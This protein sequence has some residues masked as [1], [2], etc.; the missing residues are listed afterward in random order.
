MRVADQ[1]VWGTNHTSLS[2][3]ASRGHRLPSHRVALHLEARTRRATGCCA[4][5]Q[6]RPFEVVHQRAAPHV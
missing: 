4:L 2:T 5:P 3:F 6:Y 1:A